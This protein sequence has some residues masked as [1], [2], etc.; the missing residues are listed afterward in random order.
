M[1]IGDLVR[2]DLVTVGP[3]HSLAEAAR[4]MAARNVG[5]A[6]VLTD[7]SPGILSERDILRA[8]A[9]SADLELATVAEYMT[10]SAVVAS[11]HWD[12]AAAA[13]T[14][15]EYGFRHLVVIDG[16]REVGILSIRDLAGEVF[17]RTAAAAG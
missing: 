10:W 4:R 7:E 13:Q 16:N 17:P 3:T 2:Y 8:V 9:A 1:E 5:A 11:P 15:I 6:I 12:V 14:M